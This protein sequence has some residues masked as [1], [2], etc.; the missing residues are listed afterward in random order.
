MVSFKVFDRI[1]RP[2]VYN[3]PADSKIISNDKTS[4]QSSAVK[5]ENGR[6]F[7]DENTLFAKIQQDKL[8]RRQTA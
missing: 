7:K 5:Y 4:A 6:I 3:R 8:K 2:E 1:I